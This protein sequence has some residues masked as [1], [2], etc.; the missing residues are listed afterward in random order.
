MKLFHC[1]TPRLMDR[2]NASGRIILPV[3]GFDTLAAAQEWGR[4]K[5]RQI[6]LQFESERVHK[7]P[8]HH[9]RF[10]RAWWADEDIELDRIQEIT[11]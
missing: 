3:R 9:N 4:L 2:Y 7:L 8:D 1:A 5:Q 6:I 11:D 10:G